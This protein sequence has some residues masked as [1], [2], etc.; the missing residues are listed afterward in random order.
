MRTGIFVYETTS[1]NIQTN[2]NDLELCGMASTPVPLSPGQ[3]TQSVAPG[4]YKIV[5]SQSIEVTGDSSVFDVVVLP[6]DKTSGPPPPLRLTS[7]SFS[8]VDPGALAAF[9]VV[10]DAKVVLRP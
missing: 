2:E 9:F 5:S 1:L 10:P 6:D 7:A 8:P 4:I 3:S